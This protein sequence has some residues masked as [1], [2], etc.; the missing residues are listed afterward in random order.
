M[1]RII[2]MGVTSLESIRMRHL[3]G[4]DD[5]LSKFHCENLMSYCIN[6]ALKSPDFSYREKDGIILRV[7]SFR[8]KVGHLDIA[9][10][11]TMSLSFKEGLSHRKVTKPPIK[12]IKQTFMFTMNKKY[13]ISV[14][15]MCVC[16]CVYLWTDGRTDRWMYGWMCVCVCVC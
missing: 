10:N 7:K 3:F 14:R 4:R 16:A 11:T 15:S 13:E 6:K 8:F 12:H 1:V 5:S 9:L 2:T